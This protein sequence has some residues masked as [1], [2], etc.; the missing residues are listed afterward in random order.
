MRR[1]FRDWVIVDSLESRGRGGEAGAR[2]CLKESGLVDEDDVADE[3]D[4]FGDLVV[5]AKIK[6][7]VR[8]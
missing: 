8:A 3:V 1:G 7:C 5:G 6:G 4:L 2:E